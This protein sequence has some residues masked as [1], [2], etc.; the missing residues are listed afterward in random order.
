MNFNWKQYNICPQEYELDSNSA[1]LIWKWFAN[2]KSGVR[3]T[4]KVVVYRFCKVVM[5]ECQLD[6]ERGWNTIL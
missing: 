1:Y 3:T 4:L 2:V 6:S 5:S